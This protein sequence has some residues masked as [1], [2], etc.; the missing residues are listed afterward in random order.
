MPTPLRIPFP[1]QGVNRNFTRS[2]QNG[3]QQGYYAQFLPTTAWNALNVVPYD[4]FDR[5]RGGQRPGDTKFINTQ[6][7]NSAVQGLLGTAVEINSASVN[8][9]TS[10][11][12]DQMTYASGSN[13]TTR[14]AAYS[15]TTDAGSGNTPDA[16]FNGSAGDGSTTTGAG[17]NFLSG[18]GTAGQAYRY[19]TALTQGSIYSV[20][21]TFAATANVT[22]ALVYGVGARL[23]SGANPGTGAIFAYFTPCST[24]S[25]GVLSLYQGNTVLQTQVIP[26]NTAAFLRTSPHTITL[27]QVG[28][29]FYVQIDGKNYLQ[30]ASSSNLANSQ[31]GFFAESTTEAVQITAFS[32]LGANVIP[33]NR[34]PLMM[35]VCNGNVYQAS[36]NPSLALTKSLSQSTPVFNT[37]G[38]VSMTTLDGEMYG[39]DG[40]VIGQVDLASNTV[41]PYASTA[42]TAP[43][44]CSIA[45]TWR[46]RLCLSGNSAAPQNFYMSRVGVAT[47]WDYTQTDGAQA[48][49]GS[50][51]AAGFIGEPITALIPFNDDVLL[52]G[53][54]HNL[55]R[56][57]G[58]PAQGGSID[59]VSN[60][61]GVLGP[62]A[63][64]MNDT[65]TVF[66]MGPGGI[67]SITPGGQPVNITAQVFDLG[68]RAV[69]ATANYVSMVFN[70][71]DHGFYVFI[72]PVNGS[73]QGTASFFDERNS[74]LWPLQYPTTHGPTAAALFIGNGATDYFAIL[75]GFDGYLRAL[76]ETALDDDGTAISSSLVLG[77]FQPN[78]PSG[79]C[80]VT[81]LDV[82]TGENIATDPTSIFN[83]NW[84]L[85][86]G[87]SA[88]E[89]TE[90]TPR[91][92]VGGN[93]NFP[94]WQPT[95]AQRIRGGWF[96]LTFSNSTIDTY[97]SM[98][99]AVMH[100][101]P[102]GKQ[103]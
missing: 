42:A 100:V 19:T 69:D 64:C 49:E 32:V 45:T 44:N 95:Q 74:G 71:Y 11:L 97:W 53:G 26:Q 66:F 52:I 39:V 98:E 46:G 75:G 67:Y 73:T 80:V 62:N 16:I 81:S 99:H 58:D 56:V 18:V 2:D 82:T 96:T 70:V 65:G 89:V 41:I 37:V 14:N 77:P 79:D 4:R 47:D 87:K 8:L 28:N 34:S 91:T 103:R 50:S 93:F 5:L 6:M 38:P 17:V 88:F 90:G 24:T 21:A 102:Q 12:N 83:V 61:I 63:W 23:G 27:I 36:A 84:Q 54:D 59:L 3:Q 55:W 43:V 94:G 85:N 31:L 92:T 10:L 40:F 25:A 33:V 15:G 20:N 13:L 57:Q 51:S 72:T 78:Q 30:F 29:Q 9:Q 35:A 1:V 68:F 7:N 22:N 60:S 86:G 48:F 76:T 101:E